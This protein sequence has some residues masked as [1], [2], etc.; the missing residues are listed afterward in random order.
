MGGDP[1]RVRPTWVMGWLGGVTLR[2]RLRHDELTLE[3]SLAVA[4]R[5]RPGW[6]A[7]TSVAS[8][9]V[10]SSH[11]SGRLEAFLRWYVMWTA[12]ERPED[13]PPF[14]RSFAG[15]RGIALRSDNRVLFVMVASINLPETAR[16]TQ[17]AADILTR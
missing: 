9:I 2:E 12:F 14:E 1:R 7:P 5:A 4:A 10:T 17:D 6:L 16:C 15:Q 8:F 13:A 3:Q 11:D